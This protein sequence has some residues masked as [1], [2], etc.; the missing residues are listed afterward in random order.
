MKKIAVLAGL[1]VLAACAPSGARHD[2]ALADAP[3][4][5]DDAH[6]GESLERIAYNGP[7]EHVTAH[8]DGRFDGTSSRSRHPGDSVVFPFNGSVVRVYGVRGPNGGQAAVGIDGKFYGTA[9]FYAPQKRVHALVFQSPAL[10]AG[11]HTLGIVVK[12]PV[13]GPH[14]GYVNIDELEVLQRQ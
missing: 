2:V 12:V 11:T 8:P 13:A 14:R 9:E 5:V 3:L 6:A 7:W 4:H 1:M 10:A